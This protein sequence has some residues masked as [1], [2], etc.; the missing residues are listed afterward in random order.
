MFDESAM[1]TLDDVKKAYGTRPATTAMVIRDALGFFSWAQK[2]ISSGNRIGIVGS[3]GKV[4]EVILP[5]Q[6]M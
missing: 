2:E 1:K 3:D 4:R 5:F 6:M